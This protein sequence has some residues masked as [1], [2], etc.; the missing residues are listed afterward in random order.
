M[1]TIIAMIAAMVTATPQAAPQAT[2]DRAAFESLKALN[3]DWREVGRP[4]PFTLRYRTISSGTVVVETWISSNGQETMTVFLMDGETLIAT[5]YSALRSQPTMALTSATE[6]ELRFNFRSGMN[7]PT[8]EGPY[9]HAFSV[10]RDGD[11]LM[12]SDTFRG[13][14]TDETSRWELARVR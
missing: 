6:G 12:R 2:P 7:M 3:G 10:R 5:R 11:R 9:I 1:L 8:G 14:G 4:R 13:Y